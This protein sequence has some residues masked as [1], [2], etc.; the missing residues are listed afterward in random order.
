MKNQKSLDWVEICFIAL[1]AI[2]LIIAIF[3]YFNSRGPEQQDQTDEHQQT[4]SQSQNRFIYSTSGNYD[5]GNATVI[6][7]PGGK[8]LAIK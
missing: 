2:S 1:I 3:S 4:T 5:E 6:D 7:L 8:R